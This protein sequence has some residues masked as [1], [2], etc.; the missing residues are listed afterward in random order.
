[1][2]NNSGSS[3]SSAVP[4]T[5]TTQ[6][7]YRYSCEELLSYYDQDA[8]YIP[9]DLAEY[10]EV[11]VKEPQEPLLFSELTTEEISLL[12]QSI[13]CDYVLKK[14]N[15]DPNDVGQ[16]DRPLEYRE[17]TS[18]ERGDSKEVR[19]KPTNTSGG[20]MPRERKY[21][22]NNGNMFQERGNGHPL[23]PGRGGTLAERSSRPMLRQTGNLTFTR[24]SSYDEPSSSRSQSITSPS[25]LIAK[26]GGLQRSATDTSSASFLPNWRTNSTSGNGGST[27][28]NGSTT[29]TTTTTTGTEAKS[30]WRFV[31]SGNSDSSKNWRSDSSAST[32]NKATER[33]TGKISKEFFTDNEE[34][35]SFYDNGHT[36]DFNQRKRNPNNVNSGK[37][38]KLFNR[39]FDSDQNDLFK[40]A[41][42]GP[43]DTFDSLDAMDSERDLFSAIGRSS[44]YS[45]NS[46]NYND[47][48]ASGGGSG[49]GGGRGK[50]NNAGNSR[51]RNEYGENKWNNN[52]HSG[53]G[54]NSGENRYQHRQYQ[55]T[56]QHS[57]YQRSNSHNNDDKMEFAGSDDDDFRRSSLPEWSLDDPNSIDVTRVGSFDAS[58]AFHEALEDDNSSGKVSDDGIKEKRKNSLSKPQIPKAG[59]SNQSHFE[60]KDFDDKETKIQSELNLKLDKAKIDY[61]NDPCM[62]PNPKT[63]NKKG[64]LL[65]FA[66][67]S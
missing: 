59:E 60:E 45:Y 55:Q 20:D 46:S 7:K 62:S 51:Y 48:F 9:K 32:G 44:S 53:K 24:I 35:N 40:T 5:K 43:F 54:F 39:R 16:C 27:S 14:A 29:N 57:H 33:T 38:T 8:C 11:L 18:S 52:H 19:S 15:K 3:S 22:A 65:Y 25:M 31:G 67:K 64:R 10:E 42:T 37:P 66:F 47:L 6:V 56:M 36:R 28:T 1:M 34:N 30:E 41:K 50:P 23:R 61:F 12:S 58:G 26:K 49:G 17:R 4:K 21:S 2:V 13:N 63:E